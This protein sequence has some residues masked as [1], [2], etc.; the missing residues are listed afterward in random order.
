[1]ATVSKNLQNQSS[2]TSAVL[3]T[4]QIVVNGVDYSQAFTVDNAFNTTFLKNVTINGSL[5]VY[6]TTISLGV[7]TNTSQ[8][9]N[10]ISI[11]TNAGSVNV[12]N[13]SIQIGYNAGV[14]NAP[15]NSIIL[16]AQGTLTLNATN[17]SAF[18]VAPIRNIGSVTCNVLNYDTTSKE[19]Y[20]GASSNTMNAL[21]L[22]DSSNPLTLVNGTTNKWAFYT[23]SSTNLTLRGWTGS[24]FTSDLYTFSNAGIFSSVG[25]TTT[26]DYRI[27]EDIADCY[28]SIDRLRPVEY[29]NRITGKKD[30]GFIAHE[31]QEVF[32]NLVNGEKDGETL[33]S[34]QYNSLIALLVKEIQE[35]KVRLSDLE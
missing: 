21:Q 4:T 15:A 26:S 5:L 14:T 16:N 3:N 34:I 10:S 28:E 8:L 35:L 11:G 25:C 19:I 29:F 20:T 33:Q 32:P 24:A 9:T 31:V 12:G 13:Y 17:T 27:K 30:F 7:N 23:S 1:M 2:T 6:D 18:Y 22:N